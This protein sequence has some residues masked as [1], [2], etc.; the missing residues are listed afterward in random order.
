[1]VETAKLQAEARNATGKGAARALRREDKVPA[2][3]YGGNGAPVS[4]TLQRRELKR[5]YR[6]GKFGSQLVNLEIDGKITAALPR[7]IAV[8]P[9]T[10]EPIHADFLRVES[11]QIVRVSV[12]VEYINHEKSP[13]IKRGGVLNIVRRKV[14][15]LCPSDVI[16]E[17]LECDLE[18]L[19]IG[20][21]IHIGRINLPAGAKTVISGRDFTLATVV[22]RG[23]LKMAQSEEEAGS[24]EEAEGTEE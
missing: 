19:K 8:H 15:M 21:S 14:Q 23:S 2:T 16:P 13:G 11:K 4:I 12:P 1:M 22:G 18:G 5:F 10:E 17:A 20:E 24:G 6:T 9:L 7:D 3:L